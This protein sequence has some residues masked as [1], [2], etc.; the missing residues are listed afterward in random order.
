MTDSSNTRP[1]SAYSALSG[2][3]WVFF[4]GDTPG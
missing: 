1:K 3:T 4:H 2:V